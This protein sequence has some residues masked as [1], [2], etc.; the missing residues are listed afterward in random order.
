MLALWTGA[1][2]AAAWLEG[3]ED[4][5]DDEVEVDGAVVGICVSV[6]FCG[7]MVWEGCAW[8]TCGGGG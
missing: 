5:F 7:L 1:R 8:F 2:V 4:L 3:V 6:V